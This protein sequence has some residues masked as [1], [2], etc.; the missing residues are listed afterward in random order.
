MAQKKA[1]GRA[2]ARLAAKRLSASSSR[3]AAPLD[4]APIFFGMHL[5]YARPQIEAAGVQMPTAHPR[6]AA[7]AQRDPSVGPRSRR[8][9][10]LG[11][12]AAGACVLE[13]QCSF[14]GPISAAPSGS[15]GVVFYP[16]YYNVPDRSSDPS[17]STTTPSHRQATPLA[18]RAPDRA[19][20][21]HQGQR[22]KGRKG[23]RAGRGGGYPTK[24]KGNIDERRARATRG[25]G[26][27]PASSRATARGRPTT[28]SAR[29][30][31]RAQPARR[32]GPS[33]FG[34]RCSRADGRGSLATHSSRAS[35]GSSPIPITHRGRGMTSSMVCEP[36]P[37]PPATPALSAAELDS[38]AAAAAAAV[39]AAKAHGNGGGG[40]GDTV[41]LPPLGSGALGGSPKLH[42]GEGGSSGGSSSS[43]SPL[44]Q[45]PQRQALP[46]LPLKQLG[47]SVSNPVISTTKQRAGGVGGVGRV[48]GPLRKGKW[49]PEEEIYAHYIIDNFNKGLI[50]LSRGTTLRSYLSDKLN[51]S[52]LG[53][54]ALAVWVFGIGRSHP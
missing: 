27:H 14:R 49:T 52:V 26:L 22:P 51:W 39:A 53:C 18:D 43:S 21:A 7:R 44:S 15:V 38:A 30:I 29:G 54:G 1:P 35:G 13:L 40:S 17:D 8:Q 42:R 25:P 31:E 20:R 2:E 41:P 34:A 50:S 48:G 4:V 24:G 32:P 45:S 10:L 28:T 5:A 6:T 9:I 47:R 33:A 46:P 37:A 19:A 11:R 12:A 3:R 23:A 16:A 36:F